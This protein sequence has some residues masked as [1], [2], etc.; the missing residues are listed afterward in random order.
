MPVQLEIIF[1]RPTVLFLVV[2]VG[3]RIHV[4]NCTPEFVPYAPSSR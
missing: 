2:R 3:Y 4:A 1:S